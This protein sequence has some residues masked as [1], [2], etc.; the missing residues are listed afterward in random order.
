M[1]APFDDFTAADAEK[2]SPVKVAS[3][4]V[5]GPASLGYSPTIESM[6]GSPD[7]QH[8][9]GIWMYQSRVNRKTAQAKAV[10][11]MISP[12]GM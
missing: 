6:V 8:I 1:I 4:P 12:R 11:Y 2:W 5:I 7:I 3:Y 10:P 9:H